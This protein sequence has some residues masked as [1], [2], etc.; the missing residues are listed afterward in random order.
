WFADVRPGHHDLELGAALDQKG[1]GVL[2]D[3][4]G[5]GRER[6][7]AHVRRLPAAR[8]TAR[9]PTGSP[10]PVPGRDPSVHAGVPGMRLRHHSG[11]ADRR[12]GDPGLRRGRRIGGVTL[13]D[14]VAV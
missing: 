8:W 3:I 2:P 9:R 13:A 11:H 5:L 12:P 4:T 14:G 10:A 7:P 6:L 1:P